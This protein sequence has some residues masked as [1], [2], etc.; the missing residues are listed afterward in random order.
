MKMFLTSLSICLSITIIG[1]VALLYIN[2][3]Y[4]SNFLPSKQSNPQMKQSSAWMVAQIP[5]KKLADQTVKYE[6]LTTNLKDS[7]IGLTLN[8]VADNKGGAEEAKQ[9]DFQLNDYLIK[10]L[11]K[12]TSEQMSDPAFSKSFMEKLK[13]YMNQQMT[14]GKILEIYVTNKIIQ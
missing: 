2:P 11:S 13:S 7:Y 5:T 1:I 10:E 3:S 4:A 9:R 14:E 8:A 6:Q 12:V